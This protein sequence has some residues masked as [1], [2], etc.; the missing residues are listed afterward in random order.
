MTVKEAIYR[1]LRFGLCAGPLS[2]VL[3][4]A[5][6]KLD[7][8]GSPSRQKLET[9]YPFLVFRRVREAED[10]QVKYA[11]DRYEFELIGLR[12]SAAVGDDLLETV[13]DAVKDYFMGKTRTWGAFSPTGTPY[14]TQGVRASAHYQGCTEGFSPELTEKA[15]L[16]SFAFRYVRGA[17]V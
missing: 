17:T 5:K 8:R 12:S 7:M 2:G 15:H 13:K 14:P 3:S 1:E 10:N 9:D 6:I 11:E 4:P 16:L